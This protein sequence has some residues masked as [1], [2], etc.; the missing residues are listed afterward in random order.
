MLRTIAIT[1]L[2]L[3]PGGAGTA[4][5]EPPPAN[6]QT[7][8]LVP[9]GADEFGQLE[10]APIGPPVLFFA[11]C[12]NLVQ[13]VECILFSADGGGL[14]VLDTIGSFGV[15]D[16]VW[17][18][19]VVDPFCITF[20]QQ[21]DGCIHNRSIGECF[22]HCGTL[23]KGVECVL[24]QPDNWPGPPPGLFVLD[25]LGG[26]AV[27]TRVH[28]VGCLN[29]RCITFC[30]QGNGC[31]EDNLV[32]SCPADLDCNDV[33]NGL[34]LAIL[35]GQWTGAGMYSPCPPFEP[36]DLNQDC[37]IN[38]LDLALLLGAWGPCV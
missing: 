11:G 9:P 18:S 28:V 25:D 17:V 10:A 8:T 31:V 26:F 38:G 5:V 13:G 20:C 14:Y 6:F 2:L 22:D 32:S 37:R 29:P 34:D 4:L 36:A 27:G 21:G 30:L 1:L 16:R 24:F 33:V 12:G 19:G 23:V 35:L 3:A 7:S 15:G